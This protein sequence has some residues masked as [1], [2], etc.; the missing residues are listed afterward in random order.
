MSSKKICIHNLDDPAL[1]ALNEYKIAACTHTRD[2]LRT[3]LGID[4]IAAM[5]IDLDEG[6]AFDAI[7]EALEIK[8]S[9]AVIGV[10]GTNDVQ[11]CILAQRAGCRQL[12]S[13][14]IDQNDLLVAIR[15]ALNEAQGNAAPPW[16]KTISIIGSS[17]GAG[18]TT[19]ACY[20]AMSLA[21]MSDASVAV[22]DLDLEFGTV[23][24]SWD[25]SPR[26]TIAD[27][28]DSEEID[29]HN[30]EDVM[31]ELPSGISV[32]PRP[33]LIEKA[34]SIDEEKTKNILNEVK[35]AFPYL[36]IDLPRKLDA[37]SGCAIEASDK[38]L[39]V[40]QLTVPGILNAGR[41]ADAL[42]RFGMDM[43]K[44]EFVVNRHHKKMQS[45]D[46][47]ALEKRVGKDVIGVVPNH[48]K[49]LSVASDLGQPVSG[50]N[51]VRK[52]IA[53]I[54]LKLCGSQHN[55]NQSSWIAN[56]GFGR[57]TATENA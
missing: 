15:S 26:Y 44:L 22:I 54:A 14:P 46:V 42:V 12:T 25:L 49:S 3:A 53:D 35:G 37:I 16:G 23:A 9:L 41:L 20:L 51:P 6:D 18:A 2:E 29:D 31:L 40:A 24:K 48:Y 13:K 21:D 39:I 43:D 30:I 36:V 34:Q 28:A 57:T 47:A 33:D 4:E 8:S 11:K 45:L 19:L 1:N 50:R 17:G 7:V 56:L 55:L 52:A 32:L 5:I 27:L 10:T 38:L